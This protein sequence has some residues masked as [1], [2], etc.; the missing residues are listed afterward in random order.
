MLVLRA[1]RARLSAPADR[2]EN[3]S[4]TPSVPCRLGAGVGGVGG[5]HILPDSVPSPPPPSAL[6]DFSP[7]GSYPQN[8][9]GC[10][11]QKLDAG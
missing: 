1:P 9:E 6:I 8:L 2:G 4:A 10:H 7:S 11:S 5:G 3:L